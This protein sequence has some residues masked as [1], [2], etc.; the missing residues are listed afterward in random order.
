M[1]C[2]WLGTRNTSFRFN[3]DGKK[4]YLSIIDDSEM[5]GKGKEDWQRV[6]FIEEFYN[7]YSDFKEQ[8]LRK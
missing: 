4:G 6:E 5:D 2:S 7:A 3:K 8:L 1:Y